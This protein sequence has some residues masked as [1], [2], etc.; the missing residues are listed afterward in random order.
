MRTP[1]TRLA[2]DHLPII[3]SLRLDRQAIQDHLF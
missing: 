2:S 3:A 1:L